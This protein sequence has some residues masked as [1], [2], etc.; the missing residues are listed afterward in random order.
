[1]SDSASKVLGFDHDRI[2][3]LADSLAAAA[4]GIQAELDQLDQKA[5]TLRTM[6]DGN[7]QRAYDDAHR[8]W[9]ASMTR[10]RSVLRASSTAAQ[11]GSAGYHDAEKA[12]TS[13]WV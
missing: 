7:A 9:T 8:Q 13:L 6:W 2:Q 11:Q 10:L 5:R 12:A 1:M 3:L 4:A